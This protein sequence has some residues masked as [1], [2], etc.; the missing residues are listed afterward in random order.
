MLTFVATFVPTALA[1]TL[2]ALAHGKRPKPQGWALIA[3]VAFVLGP[4]PAMLLGF[5]EWIALVGVA[6]V[7]LLGYALSRSRPDGAPGRIVAP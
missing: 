5:F 1:L 2:I 4:L 6:A 3:V 7:A